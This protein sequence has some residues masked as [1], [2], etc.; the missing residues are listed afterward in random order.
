MSDNSASLKAKIISNK[1]LHNFSLFQ[2]GTIDKFNHRII[3]AFSQDLSL[4][5]DFDLIIDQDEY[6]E[7]LIDEFLDNLDEKSFLT[8]VLSIFSI[9]K[10]ENNNSWDISYDISK[11]I[12]LIMSESNFEFISKAKELDKKSYLTFKKY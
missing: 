5:G 11:L 7:E 8:E 9:Q 6:I 2:V 3:R 10:I 4:S 12:K 1:I